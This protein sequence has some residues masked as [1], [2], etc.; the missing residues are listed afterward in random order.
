VARFGFVALLF[1]EF[2]D[3]RLDPKRGYSLTTTLVNAPE[4]TT[5]TASWNHFWGVPTDHSHD[6]ERYNWLEVLAC[7]HSCSGNP[8]PSG[9]PPTPLMSNPTSCG[10]KEVETSAVTYE[11]PEGWVFGVAPF[12]SGEVTGCE[13]VPFEPTMSIEPTTRSAGVSSGLDVNLE[14][15]QPGLLNPRGRA[16][17]HLERAKV[18][19]PEGFTLNASAADGLGS[20][21]EEQIGVDRNE[22][23]I[24]HFDEHGAPAALTFDGQTTAVL[25]DFA[26]ASEVQAALEALP[27]VSPGDITVSGRVGGPWTVDFGGSFTGQDVPTIGGV[28]TEVQR[29]FTNSIGGT[30]KLGFEGEETGP[31]P[32]DAGAA[33]IQAALEGLPGIG[34][35]QV[36]VTGGKTTLAGAAGKSFRV[37]FAGSLT[38]TDVP[39]LSADPSDL[40]EVEHPPEFEEYDAYAHIQTLAEGG[41]SVTTHVIV[42]GGVLRFNG[43]DAACPE[44]SKVA[45]G[46]LT[47]PVFKQPLHADFYLAKQADNPFNSL[48]AGYLVTKGNGAIIKVPA[49]IDIDPDT[50]Q[51]VTTFEQNPEQPFCELSL[52]FKSGNRGLITTPAECGK[53]Q[54]TYELTPWSGQP[55][56]VGKSKFTLDENCEHGFN[57]SF[58]AGSESPLAGAFTTFVSRITRGAGEPSLKGVSIDL[59]PGL[60]AKL[61]GIPYCS[62]A[63]LSGI[64]TDVGAGAAQLSSPAC[65]EASQ[66]GTVNAGLGSGS[67]FYVNTGKIYLAGPYKGSPLSL[68]VLVPGVAGP[69]DLGNVLVRVPVRLDPVTAQVHAVSDPLPQMLHGVPIDLRDLRVNLDRPAFAVNPTGCDAKEVTAAIEGAGGVTVQASD[70]FQIGECAAL[71]LRPKM[72]LRFKGGTRRTKHPALTVIL[73]PRAGDANIS[74]VSVTFPPSEILD[75]SHLEN[76]CTRAQWAADDCP[77][78]SIYGT[79]TAISP[80]LDKPLT[81]N[82]YLRSSGRGL[83]DLVLDLRGP[84]EQPIRI[85]AAGRTDT[86]KDSLRNTFEFVPDVPLSRVVLRMKGGSK[87]LLQNTTNLCAHTHHATVMFS[88]HNKRNYGV[89]PKLLANCHGKRKHTRIR[90]QRGGG[91]K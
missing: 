79:V 22:R 73:R 32:Y 51:I 27:N 35:G 10:P 90:R 11:R 67:P 34:P 55:P 6:Y 36:R 33:E 44:S 24:V 58:D 40:E 83:P 84:A 56:V 80:L 42:D 78:A 91:A 5:V 50:G 37:V 7:E 70:R 26:T 60:S 53:Y 9:L 63:V 15:P 16:T 14:I 74:R 39:S 25:P 12:G 17:A 31:L 72:S 38:G 20:C 28:N 89:A 29:F 3:V 87:G 30:F 21:S 43:A 57:P 59:P 81:G 69:F 88:A 49:R 85:E 71:G 4:L 45:T 47:T 62:D 54:S 1:P 2:I 68:A 18:T 8:V 82:V 75:Q 52:R 65:P 23:Q 66:A 19:L 46:E 86:V 61:A 76:V 41:S 48:F 77:A 64:S 13:G